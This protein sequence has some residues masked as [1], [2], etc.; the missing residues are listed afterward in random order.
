MNNPEVYIRKFREKKGFSQDYMAMELEI[1]QASYARLESGET[2]L[3][4][5]R[6]IQ[7]ARIL[8]VHFGQ[9]IG[10]DSKNIFHK[11]R[12]IGPSGYFEKIENLYSENQETIE[13]LVASKDETILKLENEIVFLRKL[14]EQK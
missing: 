7:I 12:N 4:V 13:K 1:S 10:E 9:L 3:S 11:N 6:L 8:Q 2:Q 5:Q 14:I